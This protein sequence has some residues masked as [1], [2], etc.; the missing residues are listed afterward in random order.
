MPFAL[1]G[2]ELDHDFMH[3]NDDDEPVPS[4][5]TVVGWAGML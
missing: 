1:E 4:P 2:G 5:M 3:E